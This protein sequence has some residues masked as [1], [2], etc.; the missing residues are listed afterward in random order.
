[1]RK[2]RNLGWA[3]AVIW[4]VSHPTLAQQ[5]YNFPDG[6]P[7]FITYTADILAK[8][9]KPDLVRLAEV[10]QNVWNGSGLN[11][12]HKEKIISTSKKLVNA[13]AMLNVTFMHYYNAICWGLNEQKINATQMSEFL[14]VGE[15][16]ALMKNL[17]DINAFFE[18]SAHFLLNR[19][20]YTSKTNRCFATGTFKF[21]FLDK[22]DEALAKQLS[23]APTETDSIPLQPTDLAGPII[24][25]TNINLILASTYDSTGVK[26]TEGVFLITKNRFLGK[27]GK[28]DWKS[29]ELDPNQ[30]Y[31]DL[32]AYSF[33]VS[34]AI[35][36][37][38]NV[39]MHYR[40]LFS[41]AIKGDMEFVSRP[42]KNVYSAIYPKFIS[43]ESNIS[44]NNFGKD[45]SYRGGFSLEGR[46]IFSNSRSAQALSVFQA[47]R[48]FVSEEEGK[49]TREMR[50][51]FRVASKRFAITDSL[52][53]SPSAKFSL[54]FG[55]NDSL[56]H[57]QM[58]LK[59]LRKKNELQ[60]IRDR[61]TAA[62]NTPFINSF[63]KFYIDVD[64]VRYDLTKDSMDIYMLSGDQSL[65]PAV[66]ESFDYFDRDRYTSMRGFNDFHP[67]RLLTQYA[68]K[69]GITSFYVRTLAE[70][71]RKNEG[72]LR[73][74]MIDLR[75]RGYIDF[76]DASG[77]ITL[78][79]RADKNDSTDLFLNAAIKVN[80]K[81]AGV[82]DKKLYDL[83][84]HDN[85][86][87]NSVVSGLPNASLN[88][89]DKN[90][91]IIRGIDSFMI[92]K[93]LNVK[94]IPDK[95]LRRIK[96][97]GG[98]NFFLEK[99]EITVGN[100]RF[101]G[102]DFFL[103][104]DEFNLEMPV[105]DKVL[106]AVQDTTD[107]E[108]HVKYYGGE[109]SFKPGRM[110]INDIL[111]K[112]GRKKGF[113]RDSKE[114]SYEAFP[115]LSIPE[116]G[117]VYF[118]TGYR[119]NFAY[120]STR[121]QF[122]LDEVDMDSLTSKVPIFPGSFKS[123]IFP[124]FKEI[125]LPM[126]SPDSTM[127]FVHKPPK[128]GY[129]LYPNHD[130]IK[131]AHMKFSRDLVMN[132]LGL[133]SGGEIT[134]LTATLKAPEFIFMPDSL[135][136]DNIEFKVAPGTIEGGEFAEASGKTAQLR[137]LSSEDRM[138]ISNLGEIER[139]EATRAAMPQNAFDQR[140]KD[141]L[142]ALY[143]NANPITLRGNLT[144]TTEG[145][146]GE[147]NLVRRDFTLL[148]VS[149]EPFGFGVSKFGAKNVEFRINS[150][151]RNPYQFDRG[152]FYVENKAVLLGNFVDVDIDLGAGKARIHPD[153]EFSDYTSLA[154]PYAEYRTSIKE[155]LW[156]LG[157]QTLDMEGDT[158]TYF[159]STIFG[160]EDFNPENLVFRAQKAFYDIPNLTMRLSGIPYINS[161]D[162]SIVPKEGKAIILKD[163]EMQEL[164][165][166]KVLIDTLNRYHR[167]FNGNIKIKSRLDFEGDATYQFVNVKKDTFNVKFDKFELISLADIEKT[168]KK[169]NKEKDNPEK[170]TTRKK[171]KGAA[172]PRSTFAQGTVTEED[173]FYITSKIL[174]KG[175]VKMYATRKDL[176]LD[177]FIKLDLSSRTDFN[178]WIPYKSDKGD[179]VTL[180]LDKQVKIDQDVV[181]SGLHF[182]EGT[183]DLY[184]TFMSPK[185]SD[186][187]LDIFLASGTL[188]YNPNINE[189][190]ISPKEKR[191]GTSHIGN[192]L[193]FDDSKAEIFVEGAYNFMDANAS[194]YVK[195]VGTG[196]I[197]T[198]TKAVSFDMFLPFN[199]PIQYKSVVQM[200]NIILPKLPEK[201]YSFTKG[202]PLGNKIAELVG[203]KAFKS[204][205]AE[206]AGKPT[207]IW[208]AGEEVKKPLVFSSVNMKWSEEYKTLY[209]VDSLHLMNIAEKTVNAKV[210]GYIEF[211]KNS[212]GDGFIVFIQP[213][214][215]VWYYFELEA[216]TFS[217]L[218]SDEPFNQGVVGKGVVL[219]AI[220]KKEAFTAKFKELYGAKEIGEIKKKEVAEE[221]KVE[222][223]KEEKKKEEGDGF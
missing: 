17:K 2:R 114:D 105:I 220:D 150:K 14:T 94:I 46:N 223:K 92:S 47:Q 36:A 173:K 70:S 48:E 185:H 165:E 97:F 66:F 127:G 186:K 58:Q 196:R 148:S 162:A 222:E 85:Y 78:G 74:V 191:N 205:L 188:D 217:A 82:Q 3:I 126:P 41:Q 201:P 202:D 140:Y 170:Q 207:A 57:A 169:R 23:A 106:F 95:S 31:V 161:A 146:K 98:R 43:A 4:A 33:E 163:A 20:I 26:G 61:N 121:A 149:E 101:V 50:P 39:E 69:E 107:E 204:Y 71:T 35:F 73:N 5:K 187:D 190:K 16:V 84:D 103:L 8:T 138:I 193:I 77:L 79:Q 87:I 15:K 76:D 64:V 56:Y 119:Q 113:I 115:K 215:E 37:A 93:E 27:G 124:E 40:P 213:T 147:G 72:I 6:Q 166:A 55:S 112:S 155:A 180:E 130:K 136:S 153:E 171:R 54:Y 53:T 96:I 111:N 174:Y 83:Y 143:G 156:D 29:V 75:N 172:I 34:K 151:F 49:T 7:E 131:K 38:K 206:S 30:V 28:F 109:V 10:F 208:L 132:S 1:M 45:L 219:A 184:T 129:P 216:G 200:H 135:T 139:L 44:I 25:F 154:L 65:R 160:S 21:D 62:G 175:N 89:G 158:T 176:T 178:N 118:K 179:A 214:E 120:D 144:I 99:G 142:F 125:L 183:A 194:S 100:F 12:A 182:T 203:D 52:I 80:A 51:A 123:N 189:F 86:I 128:A 209:S 63:H 11:T 152:D 212:A 117:T 137:W 104:Y 19:A 18:R 90:E 110:I 67:L 59:F 22:P 168:D 9:Q 211:H 42:R 167:L 133:F 221:K 60:M 88:R 81:T 68:Q 199:L 141:K 198:K 24:K 164:K 159:T 210:P 108:K 181:T 134:Y 13:K 32:D 116:G 192:Q 177:G 197:N 195:T 122:V 91:M 218:S 102:R 157:K 145:L